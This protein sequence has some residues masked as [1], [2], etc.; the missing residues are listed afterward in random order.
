M[1]QRK[2][3]AVIWARVSTADQDTEKQVD[4]LR[5]WADWRGLDVVAVFRVVGSSWSSSPEYNESLQKLARAAK[6]KKYDL[7]LLTRL[8]RLC[9]AGPGEL[10]ELVHSFNRCGVSVASYTQPWVEVGGEYRDLMIL[11]DGW[12]ANHESNLIGVR[13]SL[14]R[15]SMGDPKKK[16]GRP[17]GSRDKQPRRRLG[18]VLRYRGRKKTGG[19]KKRKHKSK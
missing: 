6:A 16:K 4:L 14:A 18:Y 13:T 10:L 2:R 15:D 11:L 12:F 1:K 19:K 9:R 7:L 8:D 17:K 5:S 3:R